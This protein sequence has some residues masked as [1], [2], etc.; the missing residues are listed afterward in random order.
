MGVL[1]RIDHP[2]RVAFRR[3]HPPSRFLMQQTAQRKF[4]DQTV[5]VQW[6]FVP[7]IN[8]TLATV[9]TPECFSTAASGVA[10]PVSL[11]F[12][13]PRVGRCKNPCVHIDGPYRFIGKRSIVMRNRLFRESRIDFAARLWIFPGRSAELQLGDLERGA[14]EL[15]FLHFA[16]SPVDVAITVCVPRARGPPRRS[17]TPL[18]RRPFNE[19]PHPHRGPLRGEYASK[20]GN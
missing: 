16:P 10:S 19:R 20:K 13:W 3:R 6:N 2:L 4:R 11:H 7:V 17:D 5:P 14:F 8:L 18:R 12:P 15:D 1:F 9:P